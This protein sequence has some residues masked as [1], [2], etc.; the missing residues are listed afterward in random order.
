[1][2]KK[3]ILLQVLTLTLMANY[4]DGKK[5]FNKKCSSCH[6]GFI[7]AK[8]LKNNFFLHQN[9][10]L[11]LKAPTVNMLVYAI[12]RGPKKIGEE[13]DEFREVEIEEYLKDTLFY[14]NKENSICDPYIL[15]YYDKKRSLKGEV[16]EK[17]ISDLTDF[18]MGYEKERVKKLKF[19]KIVLDS[20]DDTQKILQKAKKEN[21]LIIVKATSPNCWFC[22]KM[23]REVFSDKE[24]QNLIIKDFI[25]VEVNV[26]KQKLPFGVEKHYKKI[27]PSF[28]IINAD[29]K[30]INKLPGSWSKEDFMTFLK[31]SIDKK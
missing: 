2:I 15:K 12:I 28:F 6:E 22:K 16:S 20:L 10:V 13:G 24:I 9:K 1:M 23:D 18:F 19:K 17:E 30:L 29:K 31:E 14:P 21:K 8:I 3:I 4:I 27:T 5:I 7:D 25:L 26:D 11:K